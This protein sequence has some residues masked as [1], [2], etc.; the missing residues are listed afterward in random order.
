MMFGM[1]NAW[2]V[3]GRIF[4]KLP[5]QSAPRRLYSLADTY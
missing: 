3:K 2:T 1:K 4:A 5:S